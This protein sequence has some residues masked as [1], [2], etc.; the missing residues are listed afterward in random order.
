MFKYIQTFE[1]LP[2]INGKSHVNLHLE[3][4][5]EKEGNISD[6]SNTKDKQVI[7][8][9][10]CMFEQL[11]RASKYGKIRCILFPVTKTKGKTQK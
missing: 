9:P 3:G 8:R 1:V 2:L 5:K 7:R 6:I 10:A 11:R 4:K